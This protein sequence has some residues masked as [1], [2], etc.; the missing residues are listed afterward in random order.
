MVR[1]WFAS[2]EHRHNNEAREKVGE[3]DV[4]DTRSKN[5]EGDV[6]DQ[7]DNRPRLQRAR[8]PQL[9]PRPQTV[10]L[11]RALVPSGLD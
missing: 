11:P 9:T 6:G 1:T 10:D 4:G 5:G 2:P 3:L 7:P 8:G